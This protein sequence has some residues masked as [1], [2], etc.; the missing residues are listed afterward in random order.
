MA[1]SD[2]QMLAMN[3]IRLV[4]GYDGRVMDLGKYQPPI[5]PTTPDEI[6]EIEWCSPARFERGD[7]VEVAEV[8]LRHY[9]GPLA[10]Y[11][12]GELW[13]YQPDRRGW[14]PVTDETLMSWCMSMAGADVFRTRTQEGEISVRPLTMSASRA[15][16]AIAMA[17]A[18]CS[19]DESDG[20]YWTHEMRGHARGIAQFADRAV[21]VTQTASGVLSLA[22]EDPKP[23]HR[24]RSMRVL[25]SRWPGLP[26][27]VDTFPD[28][29]PAIWQAAWDW[30]GH[31][32]VE[33]ATARML[34]LLEFM[35]ASAVG[36]APSMAK[37]I[38]L[39]GPGGTGKS[40][41]IDLMTRWCRRG[42]IAHVSPQDMAAN[43]F[44][45]SALD[46]AVLNV[47]DDLPADS[48]TDAGDWK[49]VITGGRIDVERKGRDRYGITPTAGHI[50]AGNRLP[51]AV[52]ANSGFWRRWLVIRYD[53][54]FADTSDARDVLGPML[55][56]MDRFMAHAIAAFVATGGK[57]GRG[58]THPGCHA[59]TM[60]E[61]ENISDSVAAFAHEHVKP[62]EEGALSYVWPRRSQVYGDYKRWCASNGRHPVSAGELYRRLDDAGFP[63]R[64]VQ[65]IRRVV[66]QVTQ[67]DED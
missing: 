6:P 67:I 51:A 35:G 12:S 2:E 53:K 66:C 1:L 3:G 46:G 63:Q 52:K 58:Y 48:I 36:M 33:E 14:H 29:C 11:T 42:A 62:P 65:G 64:K 43:R 32:G 13:Q 39:F 25:P 56:E 27:T 5:P 55:A 40:T 31:H 61:W 18:K 19:H 22:V 9:L 16:G 17:K 49:S 23:E 24:V 7:D 41:M 38:L 34:A 47:V 26:E 21:V 45:T 57:G 44:A 59:E 8:L 30:W 20:D 54:V 60:T 37:A 10:V 4:P 28:D 15:R 50:Y